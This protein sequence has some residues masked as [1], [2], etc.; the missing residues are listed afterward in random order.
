MSKAIVG[1]AEL[2]GA[3]A[4]GGL[5]FLMASS[6]VGAAA[7]PLL[8]KAMFALAASG[9]ATEAGAIG[10]ALTQNRGMGITTRQ[11]AAYRQIIYSEQ[12]VPGI[13]IYQ[14][15]TGGSHDQYNFVIVLA[16]HPCEAI[17]NLYLDGRQV[18]WADQ[19][20]NGSRA[21]GDGTYFGGNA[22]SND[23][24]GPNGLHYNF[25]GLVYCEMRRGEQVSGDVITGLTAN[26]PAWAANS[27]GNPWVGG[28]TYVYLKIEYDQGQFPQLPEIK[29]TV[30]GKNNIYDPRTGAT[31]YSTNAALI[32]ADAITDSAW[33][34][35]DNTVNQTQLIAAAN[36]CDQQVALAAGGTETQ[37]SCHYHYDTSVS[38]GDVLVTLLKSCAGRLARIGGE[39]YIFPGA[40]IAPSF[41]ID[42]SMI[43]GPVD[44]TPFRS[45]PEL[46]NRV[47]GTYIAANYPYNVTGD[48]YDS[49][50]YY[51]GETQNNFPFAFQPSNFPQYASD[52]LHGYGTGVDVY[53]TEDGGV[54]L[55]FELGLPC[56][57]SVAQA[58]RLAKIHLLRNRQQGTLTLRL[59]IAAMR[60]QPCDVVQF[61]YAPEGF[62]SK[63]FEVTDW[64]LMQGQDRNHDPFPYVELTL[65]E[66]DPSV[67]NWATREEL[68]VY[69]VPVITGGI[70]YTVATP[71]NLALE[72]DATTILTLTDGTAVPRL[73]VTWTPPLDT[74][75]NNGG[76]IEAQYQFA[77]VVG[78]PAPIILSPTLQSDGTYLS[79][80]VDA[81]A[82]SGD[83]TSMFIPGIS[84]AQYQTVTV[85]I[86]AVRSSG[87][88]SSWVSVSGPLSSTQIN[89]VLDVSGG[90]GPR[91]AYRGGID[92]N[93]LQPAEP[94]ADVT[95][96]HQ[97]ATTASIANHSQD[98][99]P[100][101]SGYVRLA[102]SNASGN[103]A[104]NLKGAWSATVAYVI[105]DEV[106]Y[107]GGYWIATAANTNENPQT[108]SAWTPVSQ[109]HIL[110]YK[111]LGANVGVPA[112]TQ[113]LLDSISI[114]FPQGGPWFVRAD[115]FYAKN[116]GVGYAG[117]I[118]DS[119]GNLF[120]PCQGVTNNNNSAL[121]ASGPAPV[122]YTG[123]QTVTFSAY[124][125]DAGNATI[126]TSTAGEGSQP[127]NTINIPS[128]LQIEAQAAP[129]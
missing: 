19:G 43:V 129:A 118:A 91:L 76:K 106:I 25:G 94:G 10:D 50:G 35:N 87:A 112:N 126:T 20:T 12:R 65:Q 108:S 123:G 6:G 109:A 17:V 54:E 125:L 14:N 119:L 102:K 2:G 93:S 69:D 40:W 44:W 80:W 36:I 90:S 42:E 124:A 46:C 89:W 24:I 32:T 98:D 34:L 57:L 99:L 62:V 55:P 59:N 28:C 68:S 88:A 48:L 27:E 39:W 30:K 79:G 47:N 60:I 66:T 51:N 86:R 18:Y 63:Y 67:Y 105:G 7:F 78:K 115:Y 1:A 8:N 84:E 100:D 85:R 23:H 111:A 52:E 117:W 77:T 95:G 9:I 21:N 56:V 61:T 96:N 120:A 121:A 114:T 11:P 45:L 75:V 58:Q 82:V 103:V 71:T 116:G 26:D 37:Y 22:D 5:E 29:F 81:G 83:A 16:T 113:T 4:I 73:L 104:Y 92:L 122:S 33:G 107:A 64:K 70:P 97:S 31:G 3:V 74:Y 72:D 38:P 49:N 13:I 15:T 41:T 127:I 110:Q 101:G 53:L 128:Y